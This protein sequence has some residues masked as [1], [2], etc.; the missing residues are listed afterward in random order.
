M[1]DGRVVAPKDWEALR[2]ENADKNQAFMFREH[3]WMYTDALDFYKDIFPKG[4]LQDEGEADGD[5][6]PNAIALEICGERQKDGS[7]KSVAHRHT[8]TDGLPQLKAIR[9][10]SMEENSFC[11]MSPISYFGKA[12]TAANARF[13]HAVAVDLD[14]V[15]MEQLDFVLGWCENPFVGTPCDYIVNSGT[16][17][18][19]YWVLEEPVPLIPRYVPALQRLKH[20]VTDYMWNESTSTYDKKQYQG[21]YQ[22]FRIPNTSTKLNGAPGTPK[23]KNPY[24]VVCWRNPGKEGKT[25]LKDLMGWKTR[26]GLQNPDYQELV[27]LMETAGKTPLAVARK[28][29]PDWYER[30]I[31]EGCERGSYVVK[32]DLYDWF[33]RKLAVEKAATEGHRYWCVFTLASF[34]NKCGI[35]HDELEADAFSL[36]DELKRY[37]TVDNPFTEEDVLSALDAFEDG[38]ANGRSR[39]YTRAFLERRTAVPMPPKVRRNG[40]KQ[41]DHLVRARFSRDLDYPDGS[42]R[43]VDGR[44]K[45]SPNKSH[46]KR[47]AIIAYAAAHPG[48]TQREIAEVLGFSKTTVNKWLKDWRDEASA[49]E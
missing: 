5:G 42:W 14:G 3:P 8:L 41:E 49:P 6:R 16:G 22:G 33:L 35:S 30:R 13:L 45:G 31:E 18:H 39:R 15:G 21:I 19:L 25:R 28:K 46:P 43:N 12:R 20:D 37:D 11:F 23:R 34:A 27:E 4:F 10:R 32:R 40:R 17:L 29:W 47:D 24:E 26:G 38:R 36:L 48:A 44:P 7:L 1:A 9:E 2:K